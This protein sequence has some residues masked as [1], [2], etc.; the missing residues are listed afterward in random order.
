[1][2]RDMKEK[3]QNN[4]QTMAM[5]SADFHKGLNSMP[6]K[7]EEAVSSQ[8][9]SLD[10]KFCQKTENLNHELKHKTKLLN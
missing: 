1:M 7:V 9:L 8:L 6:A 2:V 4:A 3:Q 5:I 10:T